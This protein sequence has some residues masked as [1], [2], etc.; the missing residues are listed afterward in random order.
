MGNDYSA[1]G[2]VG[3]PVLYD[4]SR[5]GKDSSAGEKLGWRGEPN[6]ITRDSGFNGC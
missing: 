3:V 6:L 5:V 1:E 2:E 4:G